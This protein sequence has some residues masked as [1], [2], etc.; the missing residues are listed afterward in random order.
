MFFKEKEDQL[1]EIIGLWLSKRSAE[2]PYSTT[3]LLINP[4]II[5]D[6]AAKLLSDPS[7]RS[8]DYNEYLDLF[9]PVKLSGKTLEEEF[10]DG[11][12]DDT[13]LAKTYLVVGRILDAYFN[14][15]KITFEGLQVERVPEVSELSDE[16]SRA[17]LYDFMQGATVS[18]IDD[19]SKVLDK[20][21]FSE[22]LRKF[23]K[24]K[25]SFFSG[26]PF[27]KRANQIMAIKPVRISPVEVITLVPSPG[28]LPAFIYN[29][30]FGQP[31]IGPDVKMIER[32]T[33]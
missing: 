4:Q 3:F 32:L 28:A 15:L 29:E 33:A 18:I 16:L 9:H 8:E 17:G 23:F 22:G 10:N 31:K 7:Y 27:S 13:R 12:Y 5:A 24:S 1:K 6:Y 30:M 11:L 26:C 14:D 21:D 25:S 20:Y 19:G 2:E